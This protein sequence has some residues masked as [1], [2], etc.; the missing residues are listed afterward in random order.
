[1][2]LISKDSNGADVIIQT[3][4]D[5]WALYKILEEGDTITMLTTRKVRVGSSEK[6]A[7][8]AQRT[9]TLGIS[10]EKTELSSILRASGKI[11][12]APA[13]MTLGEYHSHTIEIHSRVHIYKKTW[14]SSHEQRLQQALAGKGSILIVVFDR[15][16]AQFSLHTMQ[17]T[18]PIHSFTSAIS[19]KGAEAVKQT[20]Y[21]SIV[22]QAEHFVSLYKTTKV[23]F[24]SALFW[25]QYIVEELAFHPNLQKSSILLEVHDT[26]ESGVEQ[27]LA[28]PTFIKMACEDITQKQQQ[29]FEEFLKRIAKSE[30]ATYGKDAVMSALES[31]AVSY[32]LTSSN[33]LKSDETLESVLTRAESTGATVH[34]IDSG[35]PMV[36]KIDGLGGII[37]LLRFHI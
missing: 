16:S 10:V 13:D 15:E 14:T 22:E 23:I 28:H 35:A 37:A 2:E 9:C 17:G 24:A 12:S 21:K 8:Y 5:L 4:D 20:H 30:P 34:V 36:A 3:S 1:M 18:K 26:H 25:R 11:T 31:G 19:K 7:T 29:L 6:Q 33:A 27:V 32:V